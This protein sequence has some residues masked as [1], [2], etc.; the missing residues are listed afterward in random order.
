[1][2]D[3]KTIETEDSPALALPPDLNVKGVLDD[4]IIRLWKRH[5]L[6]PQEAALESI[7]GPY[8]GIVFI[9]GNFKALPNKTKDGFTPMQFNVRVVKAPKGFVEDAAWEAWAS[10]VVLA[11]VAQVATTNYHEL[12]NLDPARSRNKDIPGVH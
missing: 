8:K 4:I 12:M 11:W 10:E 5:P 3:D 9:P 1:M 2:S 7:A 6:A